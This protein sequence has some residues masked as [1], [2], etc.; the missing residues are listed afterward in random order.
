M[1]GPLRILLAEDHAAIRSILREILTRAGAQVVACRNVLEL[2]VAV[3]EQ[4][5]AVISDLDLGD[6]HADGLLL[7]LHQQNPQIPLV[8]ITGQPG[9]P[10]HLIQIATGIFF[11]PVPD[12]VG[13]CRCVLT[14]ARHQPVPAGGELGSETMAQ[15]LPVS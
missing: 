4:Y 3:N 7:R 1:T 8:I 12:L 6:G 9:I 10:R 5:D 15:P 2:T 11:K 13:L 14:S